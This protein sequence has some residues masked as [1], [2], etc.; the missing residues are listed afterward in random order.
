MV[1]SNL[2]GAVADR[3]QTRPR[4]VQWALEVGLL[5]DRTLW[6]A[7]RAELGFHLVG[8][9]GT[10]TRCQRQIHPGILAVVPG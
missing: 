4:E 5:L 7:G 1:A 8:E 2:L 3:R 6:A 9:L 10:L